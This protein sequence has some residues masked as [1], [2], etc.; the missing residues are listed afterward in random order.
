[1]TKWTHLQKKGPTYSNSQQ[2]IKLALG[3]YNDT[4]SN[5]IG[6]FTFDCVSH[7]G[8]ETKEVYYNSQGNTIFTYVPA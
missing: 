8:T 2:I 4:L 5:D 3:K 6:S 7:I 1:M